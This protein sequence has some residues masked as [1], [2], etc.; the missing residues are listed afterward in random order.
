M[1]NTHCELEARRRRCYSVELRPPLGCTASP[2][3][4]QGPVI[5]IAPAP[6]PTAKCW[7]VHGHVGIDPR[8]QTRF[9]KNFWLKTLR[10][11]RSGKPTPSR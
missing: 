3:S 9:V 10:Y 6:T 8:P 4:R 2:K 5:G 11:Q 1:L 7:L